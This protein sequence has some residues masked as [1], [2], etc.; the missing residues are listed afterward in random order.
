MNLVSD[1]EFDVSKPLPRRHALPGLLAINLVLVKRHLTD[2]LATS[3]KQSDGLRSLQAGSRMSVLEHVDQDAVSVGA[4]SA[5]S[6]FTVQP[7]C[8][9]GDR[10]G[11]GLLGHRL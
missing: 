10:S 2:P 1:R 8:R 4:R 11:G 6:T 5:R 3:R 9:A 7:I